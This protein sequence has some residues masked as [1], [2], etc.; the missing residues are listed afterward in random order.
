MGR[1]ERL[2]LH[3]ESSGDVDDNNV[4]SKGCC[5]ERIYMEW[6]L[7][8]ALTEVIVCLSNTSSKYSRSTL[9]G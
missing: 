3:E 5:I 1:M 7:D 4:S 2:R 9:V 6:T 8:S